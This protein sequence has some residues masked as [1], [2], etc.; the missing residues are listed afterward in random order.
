VP[1]FDGLGEAAMVRLPATQGEGQ[2][3]A[4]GQ[5]ARDVVVPVAQ[6]VVG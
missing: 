3:P 6:H 2:Q 5:H 4:G 1:A